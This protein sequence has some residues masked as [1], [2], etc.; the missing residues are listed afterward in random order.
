[1][2]EAWNC[3][4]ASNFDLIPFAVPYFL[5]AYKNLPGPFEVLHKSADLE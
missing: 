3:K 5:P 2:N 1:M 4:I